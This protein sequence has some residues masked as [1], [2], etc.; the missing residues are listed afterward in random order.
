MQLF[1]NTLKIQFVNQ[2]KNSFIASCII[3]FVSIVLLFFR[4]LD[5]SIDFSGGT[6]LNLTFDQKN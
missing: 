6:T 2:F 4:G 1:N 5:S 3:C